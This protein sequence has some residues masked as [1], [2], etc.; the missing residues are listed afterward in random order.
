MVKDRHDCSL[1]CLT[2]LTAKQPYRSCIMCRQQVTTG[3]RHLFASTCSNLFLLLFYLHE[4]DPDNA[5]EKVHSSYCQPLHAYLKV[6]KKE[7]ADKL[8]GT[9]SFL[10][11]FTL[12]DRAS[13]LLQEL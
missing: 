1:H 12:L 4:L 5:N 8:H 2:Q 9:T 3:H 11:S 13:F 7:R 10:P 6:E